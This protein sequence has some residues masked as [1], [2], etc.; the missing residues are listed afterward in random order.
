MTNANLL[1]YIFATLTLIGAIGVVFF[2]HF[3]HAILSLLLAL[4]SLCGLLYMMGVEILSAMLFWHLGTTSIFVLLHTFF[5]LGPQNIHKSPRR[6]VPGKLFF[7]I[8]VIYAATSLIM[9]IPS[10]H[11]FA[12]RTFDMKALMQLFQ[13][14]YAFA[15]FLLLALS[16]FIFIS[17]LLLI[18]QDKNRSKLNIDGH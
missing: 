3:L 13:T 7:V 2:R 16:P 15:I 8:V 18:R 1:P 11:L 17:S 14:E 5:L 12:V 10:F 9:A 6:L 4:L